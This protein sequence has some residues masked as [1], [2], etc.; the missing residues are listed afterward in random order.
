MGTLVTA[1]VLVGFDVEFA[2]VDVD[3]NDGGGDG[4]VL[5]VIPDDE[6]AASLNVAMSA[7]WR[8]V[9]VVVGGGVSSMTIM[10]RSLPV[11]PSTSCVSV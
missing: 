4:D 1:T 3:A 6:D 2:N 8:V 9:V 10:S 5:N 7:E 11:L